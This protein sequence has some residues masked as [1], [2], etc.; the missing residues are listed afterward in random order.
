MSVYCIV[1]QAMRLSDTTRKIQL[2]EPLAYTNQMAHAFR[3]TVLPED[4]ESSVD[5]TGV[6]VTGNFQKLAVDETVTPII[7]TVNGAVAEV[8]LP[9]SCY[10]SPGRFKFTLDLAFS[11]GAT[12]IDNILNAYD[13][14]MNETT[15]GNAM[16]A[17]LG[18]GNVSLLTRELVDCADLYSAGWTDA[19][20]TGTATVFTVS[21]SAGTDGVPYSQNIILHMT[22]IMADGTIKTPAQ[23]E[24]YLDTLLTQTSIQGIINKDKVE[25][26][27]LGLLLWVQQVNTSWTKAFEIADEYDE[28]LHLLQGAYY[29]DEM[30]GLPTGSELKS[31]YIIASGGSTTNQ[32]RTALWVEGIVERNL[33][34]TIIDP[35]TPVANITQA[36]NNANA[37]AAS[38]T[39]AAADAASAAEDA[40]GAA[41]HSVRYD[42]AQTIDPEDQAQARSNIGAANVTISGT[43]I[44]IA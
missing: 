4:G 5:L 23:I 31:M 42:E 43:T 8:I 19:G 16:V 18:F 15:I 26:N 35:G 6:G 24:S 13:S 11:S 29:L 3:V 9:A 36:I 1:N 32:N 25:N 10:T 22:P 44:V 33:S 40:E 39:S 12:P 20:T 38:A 2:R 37:A 14:T 21:Y 28:D 27:G 17:A 7:G 30:T 34:G 41:Q